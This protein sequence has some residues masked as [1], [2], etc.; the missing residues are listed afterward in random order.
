MS[1]SKLKLF[2]VVD[3]K[4]ELD[5]DEVR[6]YL[7]LAKLMARDKG[8]PGDN[9]GSKKLYAF[10][11][12][13]YLYFVCDSEAYPRKKGLSPLETHNYAVEQ[14]EL[15]ETYRPDMIMQGAMD[16]YIDASSSAAQD[17]ITELLATI[18]NSTKII[19]FIRTKITK[20]LDSLDKE[21]DDKKIAEIY[22]LQRDLMNMASDVPKTVK[23]LTD[24]YENLKKEESKQDGEV[25]YGGGAIP[26]SADPDKSF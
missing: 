1:T 12:F 20:T 13:K 18:R 24:A 10:K 2:R 25:L 14:A 9:T 4:I 16:F 17:Y 7:P 22:Q 11:E 23:A 5:K 3:N 8:S 21:F 19:Q 15:P 6:M 26:D